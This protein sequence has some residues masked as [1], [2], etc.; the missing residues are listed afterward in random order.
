MTKKQGAPDKQ[1]P[2]VARRP[3][4]RGTPEDNLYEKMMRMGWNM[5]EPGENPGDFAER[6]R[7]SL[8]R[9]DF[10]DTYLSGFRTP[11]DQ[12][13]IRKG[14]YTVTGRFRSRHDPESQRYPSRQP[15]FGSDARERAYRESQRDDTDPAEVY[16]RILCEN[17]REERYQLL[18][19]HYGSEKMLIELKAILEDMGDFENI[20]IVLEP[21]L[22]RKHRNEETRM[23]RYRH[24][25]KTK[26]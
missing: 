23:N 8:E 20:L 14:E 5:G 22:V 17:A 13:G 15:Y 16:E 1:E 7:E 21:N 18:L 4:P 3:D 25:R 9:G 11:E 2:P 19:R 24:T 26:I 6:L 10:A 12:A